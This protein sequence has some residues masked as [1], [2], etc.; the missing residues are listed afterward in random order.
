MRDFH[1]NGVK[2][3]WDLSSP[4]LLP[5][6]GD[7]SPLAESTFLLLGPRALLCNKGGRTGPQHMALPS[8]PSGSL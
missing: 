1:K 8:L 2:L 7:S 3:S 6:S 4:T 5:L